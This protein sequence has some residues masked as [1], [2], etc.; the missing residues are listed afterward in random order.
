MKHQ[1]TV[2]YTPEQNGISERCN[3]NLCTKVRVM[4]EDANLERKLW[5]EAVN[6]GVHLKNVSLTK[7]LKDMTPEEA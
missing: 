5:A 6:N 2:Q 4:L 7:A 3:R 1:L